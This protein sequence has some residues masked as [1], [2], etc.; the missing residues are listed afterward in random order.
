M[1]GIACM[2]EDK[3]TLAGDIPTGSMKGVRAEKNEVLIANIEGT[4][5]AIG[6]VCTHLGCRLSSGNLAGATVEC[7]CHG[8]RFSVKTGEV[9][10]GPAREPEPAGKVTVTDGEL[11]VGN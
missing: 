3:V 6:N 8:S 7:P 11:H 10:R 5:F 2:S 1:D 4:Y 9:L